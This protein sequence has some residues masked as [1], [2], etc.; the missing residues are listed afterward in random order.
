MKKICKLF[1]AIALIATFSACDHDDPVVE[2]TPEPTVI[3]TRSEAE[4]IEIRTKEYSISG[5][6]SVCDIKSP[7]FV[8]LKDEVA[9]EEINA[10][11]SKATE[12]YRKEIDVVSEGLT[13]ADT[14]TGDFATKFYTYNVTYDRYNNDNYISI[15]IRQNYDT[16][17]LRSNKWSDIFVV[18]VV[19]C[20][21]VKLLEVFKPGTEGNYK[22]RIIEEVNSQAQSAGIQ[23]FG[24]AGISDLSDSQKFF[25]QD[26][27][28]YIYFEAGLITEYKNDEL[29]FKMPFKYNGEYFE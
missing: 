21:L 16:E 12:P 15:I 18:D 5:R 14:N 9:Q 25:I 24:G 1:L 3:D 20:K 4:K 29:A 27:T 22:R 6:N 13:D 26:D 10:Q 8:N 11:I 28:L 23:V 17:G 2:T 19:K 7:E